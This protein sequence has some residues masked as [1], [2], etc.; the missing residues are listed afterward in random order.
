MNSPYPESIHPTARILTDT[1]ERP[2]HLWP[3][4]NDLNRQW[5]SSKNQWCHS[6]WTIDNDTPGARDASSTF[7]WDL[8]LPDGTNL[9]DAEHAKLLDWLRRLI[10]SLLAAPG[11][12]GAVKPGTM[13][14]ISAGFR[15]WI[16][17]LVE[18]HIAWPSEMTKDV[19]DA[20]VTHL[21][22][23]VAEEENDAGL[24]ETVAYTRLRP[25]AI[26][27]RQR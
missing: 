4:G 2:F 3:P 14:Q 19:V 16:K 26:L 17:W 15:Y 1:A 12:R 20:Y 9:L 5:V 8:K 25:F 18:R 23:E 27:W 13:S 21:R 22:D 24:T 6:K 7:F 10:W 11:E